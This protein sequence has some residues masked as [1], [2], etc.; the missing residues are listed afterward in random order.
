MQLP[1]GGGTTQLAVVLSVTVP[2]VAALQV[3]VAWLVN[4]LAAPVMSTA[5]VVWAGAPL[6]KSKGIL[7]T[8]PA[9]PW[10]GV[11]VIEQ[12]VRS[13]FPVLDTLNVAWLTPFTAS[14]Q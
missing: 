3:T 9:V 5:E 12:A 10:S 13:T 14:L 4:V 1:G 7:L 6:A 8:A 11:S 2:P